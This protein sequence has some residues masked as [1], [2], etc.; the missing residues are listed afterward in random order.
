MA[1]QNYLHLE[2]NSNQKLYVESIRQISHLQRGVIVTYG[3]WQFW[4]T[5]VD[6]FPHNLK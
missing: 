3:K 1:Q 5:R 2:F 4:I 6:R